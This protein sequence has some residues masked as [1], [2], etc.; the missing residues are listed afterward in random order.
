MSGEPLRVIIN[1]RI[2]R[3]PRTGIGHYIAELMARVP[4]ADPAIRL[5]GVF[6]R[7]GAAGRGQGAAAA[8]GGRPE[9]RARRE[10]PAWVRFVA[11]T[12]YQAAFRFF[13]AATGCRL[14]HEPGHVP[15]PWG[16]VTLTTMHD[17]SV[18]RYPQWHPADRV[19]WH[20]RGLSLAVAR[21][22]HFVAVSE[23]T[24]G[25]M[26]KLLGVAPER[27]SVI[28]LG[29]REMFRPRPAGEVCAWLAARKLPP[30]YLLY[31]GAIEPRKN[32]AGL[33]EAYAGLAVELR[34]RYPLL[35]AGGRAWGAV[36]VE[37]VIRRHGVGG[38]VR[39]LGYQGDEA[40]A[41]LYAGAAALVWPTFYEGFGLPPLEAMACGT[42]VIA[43]ASSSVPEVVG[44]AGLLIEP[45]DPAAIRGAMRAVLED[46]GAAARLAEA[47]L[48]RAAE[49]SW[50]RCAAAHAA[51]YRKLGE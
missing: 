42:P 40:L 23:F 30:R 38:Q 48:R 45:N 17:L 26:T 19:R 37:D 20:E 7:A 51:L 22:A 14:Y 9:Q 29:A 6:S 43:S 39:L 46:E 47:G 15:G 49:F 8:F 25:E 32:L 4:L 24:K 1:D 36:N 13:G 18:L 28:H 2:L 27:V 16:G 12:G 41:V 31:V 10:V 44:D 21:S 5:F 3:S 34:E 50:E 33:V 35:I 11:E